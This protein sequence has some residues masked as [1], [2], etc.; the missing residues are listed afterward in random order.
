MIISGKNVGRIGLGCVTFGREIDRA[1]SFAMME[2]ALANGIHFFDTA[3]AYGAGA[4][5]QIIGEWLAFK[6]QEA[7]AIVIATKILPPY[8][9]AAIT[10]SVD[11]CRG[12]LQIDTIDL[13]FLHAWHDDVLTTETLTALDSLILSGVVKQLGASNFHPQQLEM[14]LAMQKKIAFTSLP[15]C[16]E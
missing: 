16:P 13:L 10:Q 7:D 12:R 3:A 2:H 11:A 15:L 1:A 4:S 8:N 14:A 6:R 9:A 5:E